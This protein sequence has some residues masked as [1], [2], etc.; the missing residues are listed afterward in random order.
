MK[1]KT[2]HLLFKVLFIS[3]YNY[4]YIRLQ[5]LA[6]IHFKVTHIIGYTYLL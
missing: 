6:Y 5:Y 4:I 1:S 2:Q 3:I